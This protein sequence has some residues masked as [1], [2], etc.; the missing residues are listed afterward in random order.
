MQIERLEDGRAQLRDEACTFAFD[1]LRPG[2][3]LVQIEGKDSGQFGTAVIDEF[4]SEL[5]RFGRLT[6]LIDAEHAQA[7]GAPVTDLWRDFF[8]ANRDG[9]ESLTV[10]VGSRFMEFIVGVTTHLAQVGRLV[11][12]TTDA[13]RFR[14]D[15]ERERAAA[16]A[17]S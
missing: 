7:A 11:T 12:V 4:R 3:L 5:Q 6:L 15:V 8:K 16:P 14:R 9:L 1:R 17:R 10:L 2:T 13:D